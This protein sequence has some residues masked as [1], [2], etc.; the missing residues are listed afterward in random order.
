MENFMRKLADANKSTAEK[1]QNSVAAAAEFYRKKMEELF[2]SGEP[3]LSDK[4]LVAK[5]DSHQN[6]AF[7]MLK[8]EL[9]KCDARS[10]EGYISTMNKVFKNLIIIKIYLCSCENVFLVVCLFS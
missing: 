10:E 3:F 9:V 6:S 5:H 2:E 4:E 8:G 1:N 7:H